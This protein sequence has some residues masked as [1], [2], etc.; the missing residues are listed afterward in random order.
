M[1]SLKLDYTSPNN[2]NEQIN[3]TTAMVLF[4]TSE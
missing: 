4:V 2:N 1:A 3:K